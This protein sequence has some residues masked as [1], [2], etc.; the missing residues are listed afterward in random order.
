MFS[1]FMKKVYLNSE[2]LVSSGIRTHVF[3]FVAELN[4]IWIYLGIPLTTMI[5]FNRL[6]Q[7]SSD[8]DVIRTALKKSPNGLIEVSEDGE[9]IRRT[10]DI[11]ENSLEYW[12]AV[13]GRTAYVVCLDL[14]LV[15][16][17]SFMVG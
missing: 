16:F 14:F 5:K 2:N 17:L 3:C 7:L 11:P 6:K 12:Q 9:K 4:A 10:K 8:F 15:L 1:F 13:K